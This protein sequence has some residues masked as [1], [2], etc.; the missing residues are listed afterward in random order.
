MSKSLSSFVA[1]VL[2]NAGNPS[3]RSH[4]D[5]LSE[6]DSETKALQKVPRVANAMENEFIE[7][8]VDLPFPV[9]SEMRN[10]RKLSKAIFW[11]PRH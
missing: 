6:S 3:K 4:D 10:L 2:L 5:H 9:G 8:S 7:L 11:G 1:E